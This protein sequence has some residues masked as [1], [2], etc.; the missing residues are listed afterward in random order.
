MI[1]HLVL[2]HMAGRFNPW[3]YDWCFPV[4][5]GAIAMNAFCVEGKVIWE[6]WVQKHFWARVRTGEL[7]L[8]PKNLFRKVYVN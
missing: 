6:V 4:V 5:N 3:L 7:G 2:D 1:D 8:N